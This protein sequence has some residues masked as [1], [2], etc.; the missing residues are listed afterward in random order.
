MS[1][2]PRVRFQAEDIWQA[3]DDGRIYEVI[4]GELY[5]APSPGTA[6]QRVCGNLYGYLWQYLRAHPRGEVF[7][8]PLGVVLDAEN[9]VQPDLVYVAH[10]R[11]HIITE[12]GIEGVPDL[13]VEVLS[14]STEARDRGIKLRRYARAGVPHYWIVDPGQRTLEVYRLAEGGYMLVGRYGP[15]SFL[16][17]ELFPGLELSLDALWR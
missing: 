6:H 12:R 13:V 3:P 10:E 4:D 2:R 16:R 15:G 8:A 7:T 17:P 11:A 14:P 5:V 9:A 1:V